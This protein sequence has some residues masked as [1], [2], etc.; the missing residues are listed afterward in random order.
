MFCFAISMQH[1]LLDGS[2]GPETF[3]LNSKALL[4]GIS[5]ASFGSHLQMADAGVSLS[6][7]SFKGKFADDNQISFSPSTRVPNALLTKTTVI[8]PSWLLEPDSQVCKN[9][10]DDNYTKMT[11]AGRDP[12]RL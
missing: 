8:D 4:S 9:S 10:D 12:Q 6:S 1:F 11:T 3:A 7:K 5:P 2:T